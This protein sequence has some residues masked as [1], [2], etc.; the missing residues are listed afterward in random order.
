[1]KKRLLFSLAAAICMTLTA[2]TTYYVNA[3]GG[4][5]SYAGTTWN[6]AF[7]TF[8][9][10]I[11]IASA[12]DKVWIATGTYTPSAI[13]GGS[14]DE[15]DK[16]F[17]IRDI[18]VYG[19]FSGTETSLSQRDVCANP[20]ILSGDLG[21][22]KYAYHVAI[23][24]GNTV[25]TTLDGFFITKGKADGTGNLGLDRSIT[26]SYA[27]GI[28]AVSNGADVVLRNNVIHDNSST[29]WGGGVFTLSANKNVY[30]TNNVI[31]NNDGAASNGGGIYCQAVVGGVTHLANNLL[32]GNKVTT[33]N[34]GNGG[35]VYMNTNGS[36][37]YFVNNT[38]Y[39]NSATTASVYG[40]TP[41]STEGVI[42]IQ[43]SI[44]YG[45]TPNF[46]AG[47][48]TNKGTVSADYNIIGGGNSGGG[49]QVTIGQML[50]AD[51]LFE[52]GASEN[53]RL[54]GSSPAINL[55]NNTYYNVALY[56]NADI[57]N[58]ER[59]GGSAIDFGA[60][61]YGT[62]TATNSIKGREIRK[63]SVYPNPVNDELKMDLALDESSFIISDLTGRQVLH[64]T[65]QNGMSIHVSSLPAGIYLMKAG[66]YMA[67]FV[68]K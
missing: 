25:T 53:F 37:I 30:I 43:N 12:G 6:E 24:I 58:K 5:D 59:I 23:V 31:K 66:E 52:D 1:M 18:S 33:G 7:A 48:S 16:S 65:W 32:Y 54:Q 57:Y 2:Q 9:K 28:N 11:E 45:N 14:G 49:S 50:D 36:E 47:H 15:R 20:T 38:V 27:G 4:D 22:G 41:T 55:G 64:G 61:E 19:G 39:G 46:I 10:A 60:A 62:G 17:L 67:K 29:G 56:G 34:G 3:S 63:F 40:Y 68:K 26:R 21:S 8:Q 51:P 13:L 35:A 42:N 44:I